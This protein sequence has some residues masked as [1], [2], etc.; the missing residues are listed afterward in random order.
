MPPDQVV[1]PALASVRPDTSDLLEVPASA[2]VPPGATVVVPA[3]LNDPAL[4]VKVPS[5]RS[6][7]VPPMVPPA[8]DVAAPA[9]PDAV[10]PTRTVP[11][12]TAAPSP[13]RA[14][15]RTYVP[16]ANVVP[17]NEP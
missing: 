15:S 8:S 6:S 12:V 11:P 9:G 13:R 5:T 10:V 16:L 17:A 1:V 2:R 7:P 3:S 14:P 4:H